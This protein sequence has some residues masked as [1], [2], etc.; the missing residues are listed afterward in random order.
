M[1]SLF[2]NYDPKTQSIHTFPEWDFVKRNLLETLDYV[3]VRLHERVVTH[4]NH[5]VLINLLMAIGLDLNT[6][7]DTYIR[8]AEERA[9]FLTFSLGFTSTS[10]YGKIFPGIFYG[11]NVKEIIIVDDNDFDYKRHLKTWKFVDPVRVLLCPVSDLSL[12]PPDG[13]EVNTAEGIAVLSVNLKKLLFVYYMWVHENVDK[14][15]KDADSVL[16]GLHHMIKMIIV[17]N[18]LLTQINITIFNRLMNMYYGAPFDTPLKHLEIATRDIHKRVDSSLS[19]MLSVIEKETYTYPSLMR[20]IKSITVDNSY[21]ALLMPENAMTRQINWSYAVARAPIF[22]FLIE[23]GGKK[24]IDMN[25]NS[26]ADAYININYLETEHL[27]KSL[28]PK[29]M[30]IDLDLD[31]TYISTSANW[32]K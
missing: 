11:P 3:L 25:K 29:D 21:T 10:S 6:D 18:M 23:V 16:L 28:L 7:L 8:M 5:H 2:E 15:K 1:F 20:S 27:L 31:L 13:L 22:R 9:F 14:Y 32:K 4:L 19:H 17:P 12:V 30:Y 24:D 26:L